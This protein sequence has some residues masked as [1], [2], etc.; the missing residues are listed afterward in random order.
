MDKMFNF[1][2]DFII[3]FTV[4]YLLYVLFFNKKR[5]NYKTLKKNDEVKLF[6]D[7]YNLDMKKIKKYYK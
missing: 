1:L 6:I 4:V 5:R 3:V 7:R 2:L